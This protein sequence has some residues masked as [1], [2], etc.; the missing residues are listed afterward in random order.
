MQELGEAWTWPPTMSSWF[1]SDILLL[2]TDLTVTQH[3]IHNYLLTL[4][5][6]EDLKYIADAR[7]RCNILKEEN[8]AF[9]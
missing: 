6:I 1:F 2:F 9:N 4:F 5:G 7:D 8:E 3:Y